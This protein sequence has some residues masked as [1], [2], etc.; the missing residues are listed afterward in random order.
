MKLLIATRN[1]GKV[2]EMKALLGMG[3][4]KNVEVVTLADMPNVG[5][6]RE[7]GKTFRE[8]AKIKAM[9]H[10]QALKVLCVADD[11]GLAVEALGGRPGV[12]SARY[13]GPKATDPENTALL[14]DDL[15]PHPRPWKAAF[16]CVAIAVL[17]GR[18]V[19]E[20]EGRIEGEIVP[21][22]RGTGGFGY[23]PV[24]RVEGSAKTM[25]ELTLEEKNRASHRGKAMRG[26]IEELK[27]SGVFG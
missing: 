12:M 16:V 10:A 23:D 6:P 8:N 9:Y 14:L 19:A 5:D 18:V 13:A 22:P 1:R 17:P 7:E 4:L 26:L 2:A 21:V 24:F 27:K 3:A 20:S 15:K 25:A 11:S